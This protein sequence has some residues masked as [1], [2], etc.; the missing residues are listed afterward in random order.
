VVS[1]CGLHTSVADREYVHVCMYVCVYV[2][3]YACMMYRERSLIFCPRCC[4]TKYLQRISLVSEREQLALSSSCEV[5][6]D[7]TVILPSLT[8]VA[9]NDFQR[10]GLIYRAS[11]ATVASCVRIRCPQ[12][13][14]LTPSSTALGVS[15]G[16]TVLQ[17]G[18]S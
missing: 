11:L 12:F 9:T 10:N 18:R 6:G 3:M 15:G 8:F 7:T 2:C 4:K 5:V 17:V 1:T 14:N 16:S 13:C